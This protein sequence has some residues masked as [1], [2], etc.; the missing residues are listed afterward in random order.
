MKPKNPKRQLKRK[1]SVSLS[2]DEERI[3]NLLS[4]EMGYYNFS[5][6]LRQIIHEWQAS[7]GAKAA[8]Q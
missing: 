7:R 1:M 3:V 6:A 5:L 4:K 8:A 2:A